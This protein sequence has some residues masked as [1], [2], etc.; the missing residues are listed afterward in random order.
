VTGVNWHLT[1][2]EAGYIVV[3][4]GAKALVTTA[5]LADTAVVLLPDVPG[6]RV[7]HRRRHRGGVRAVRGGDR[8]LP[9]GRGHR[10]PPR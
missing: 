2:A 6:C 10:A 7:R 1:A 8:R 4:T 9:G 3:N 5:A